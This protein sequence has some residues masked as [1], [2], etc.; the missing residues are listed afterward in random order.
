MLSKGYIAITSVLM[1]AAVAIVVVVTI[2]LS[3]ISEGQ[4][5]LSGQRREATI[6]L[7]ES[8]IEDA[9]YSINTTNS[10]GSSITLPIGTC[11][12]TINSHVGANWTFTVSGTLNG[13]T[14][15]IQITTVRSTTMTPMTW[16][17]L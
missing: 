5:S 8:C 15:S 6:D 7:V 14:K 12:V 17:E 9:L 1:I 3:S 13:Y 10:L 2:T 11:S 4:V 16:K